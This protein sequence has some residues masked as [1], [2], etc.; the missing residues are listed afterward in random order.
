MKP[1]MSEKISIEMTPEELRSWHKNR[2]QKNSDENDMRTPKAIFDSINARFGPFT[3]DAAASEE[4]AL[5]DK[6]YDIDM[7]SLEQKWEGKVWCNPPYSS[8]TSHGIK[9]FVKKAFDSV[10]NGDAEIV[11]LLIRPT[12]CDTLMWHDWIFPHASHLIFFKGRLDF[13]GPAHVKGGASRWPSVSV[14]FSNSPWQGAGGKQVLC[15]DKRGNWL[16]EQYWDN[17]I[18]K[19]ALTNGVEATGQYHDEKFVVFRGSTANKE[20]RA[21]WRKTDRRWRDQL[22]E[23][24]AIVEDGKHLRFTRDVTFN[25]P[26]AAASLV[27]ACSS[28]GRKLWVPV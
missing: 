4:N 19:L 28:N 22:L 6:Y 21:S 5:C 12:N 17:D 13:T 11:V 14:V 20:P 3:L 18:L 15:M 10:Q 2:K 27:R 8:K 23:Q 7:D 16:S 1:L 9:P 25:S 26:S 24:G